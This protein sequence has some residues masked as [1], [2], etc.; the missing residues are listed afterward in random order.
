[1][2]GGLPRSQSF[3]SDSKPCMQIKHKPK[4]LVHHVHWYPADD[5]HSL[6]QPHAPRKY[7]KH[8]SR[9]G[10][11]SENSKISQ[12]QTDVIS[13]TLSSILSYNE[14]QSSPLTSAH[15]LFATSRSFGGQAHQQRLFAATLKLSRARAREQASY[16]S[17][18]MPLVFAHVH[19]HRFK[20]VSVAAMHCKATITVLS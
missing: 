12:H 19:R 16:F 11:H 1:M 14:N 4:S 9:Q 5:A 17:G 2:L 13:D 15:E 7:S 3:S 8:N 10:N 6:P 20:T 18:M